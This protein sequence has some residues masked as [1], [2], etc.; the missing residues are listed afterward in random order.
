[1]K[2]LMTCALKSGKAE[3]WKDIEGTCIIEFPDSV[4]AS[5]PRVVKFCLVREPGEKGRW[6]IVLASHY[7]RQT[8]WWPLDESSYDVATEQIAQELNE[9]TDPLVLIEKVVRVALS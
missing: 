5:F 2:E 8:S 4:Y 9:L 6:E 7:D 3:R 1:M